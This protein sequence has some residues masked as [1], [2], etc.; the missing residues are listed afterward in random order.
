AMLSFAALADPTRQRIVGLLSRGE[1]CTGDIATRLKLSAPLVSQHLKV[2][3][4]A[5]LVTMRPNKQQRFYAVDAATLEDM[6]AWLLRMGGFWN[7]RLDRLEQKL[8]EDKR[9]GNKG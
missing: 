2:L 4:E 3:R 7:E 1:R 5:R 9:H 8:R 6:A